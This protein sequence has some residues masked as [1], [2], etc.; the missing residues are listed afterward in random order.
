VGVH[1]LREPDTD[2]LLEICA[3]GGAALGV[4]FW[5]LRQIRHRWTRLAL[6]LAMAAGLVTG[7]VLWLHFH[8]GWLESPDARSAFGV[9]L[10]FGLPIF[11]LLTFVGAA[12]E[13][14]VE[15][16]A[17]C[18]ALGLG[19]WMFVRDNPTS[20]AIAIGGPA[21]IYFLYTTRILASL[22]VF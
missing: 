18:A 3:S 15:I 20:Q 13:S 8:P 14:E 7:G 5:T 1:F 16:G 22:R 6:S 12:E 19:A 10:I 21:A 9:T 4:L 2:R 11:Y 17:I